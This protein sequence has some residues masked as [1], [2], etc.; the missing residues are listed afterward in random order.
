MGF[1]AIIDTWIS[2]INIIAPAICL[3]LHLFHWTSK[4]GKSTQKEEPQSKI[5]PVVKLFESTHCQ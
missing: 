4:P 5:T 1:S 3:R 2:E